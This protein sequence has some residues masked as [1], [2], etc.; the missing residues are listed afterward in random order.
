MRIIQYGDNDDPASEFG[1][2][3]EK[4]RKRVW[5]RWVLKTVCVTLDLWIFGWFEFSH[6]AQYIIDNLIMIQPLSQ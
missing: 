5:P 3:V 4:P 2:V 6:G 1:D